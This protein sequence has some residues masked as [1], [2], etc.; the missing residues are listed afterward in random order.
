MET[1]PGGL[2]CIYLSNNLIRLVASTKLDRDSTYGIKGFKVIGEFI[3]SRTNEAGNQFTM[4]FNQSMGFDNVL[5]NLENL[6]ELGCLK[7][8]GRAYY[9]EDAPDIKF[10]FK[11]F[12]EKYNESEKLRLVVQKLIEENYIDYIQETFDGEFAEEDYSD[13]EEDNNTEVNEEEVSLVEC[14]DEEEDI[15]LGSDGNY[16]DGDGDE[17]DYTPPKKKKTTKKK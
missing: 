3:K 6:K 13:V 11:T 4:I 10:T 5:T 17:V 1:L 12:K 16:Y 14:V 9:F 15:W 2:S 8:N 7:G